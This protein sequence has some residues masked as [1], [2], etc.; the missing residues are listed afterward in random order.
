MDPIS[1]EYDLCDLLDENISL[2]QRSQSDV[3]ISTSTSKVNEESWQPQRSANS[4]N[5]ICNLISP[6]EK[7]VSNPLNGDSNE[8]IY[9]SSDNDDHD[10]SVEFERGVD[11]LESVDCAMEEAFFMLRRCV[12]KLCLNNGFDIYDI[13]SPDPATKHL[14]LDLVEN[15][16]EIATDL[17][18]HDSNVPQVSD[19]GKETTTTDTENVKANEEEESDAPKEDTTKQDDSRD[20]KNNKLFNELL[21]LVVEVES[22]FEHFTTEVGGI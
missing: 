10:L 15:E 13:F 8:D 3:L 19:T 7:F 11:F 6:A 14:D 12:K 16:Q 9:S 21:T 17:K 2:I 20:A 22:K 4:E 18:N 5:N 1:Q